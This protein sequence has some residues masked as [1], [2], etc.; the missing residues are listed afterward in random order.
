MDSQKL[1]MAHKLMTLAGLPPG[2]PDE[3]ELESIIQDMKAVRN[4]TDSDWKAAARRHVRNAGNYKY[5]GEDLTD[6]NSLLMQIIN[7][8]TPGA[9]KKQR[10]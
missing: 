6:L 8:P 1:Q 9:T 7:T 3:Q 2:H 10:Y 5:A 4:P